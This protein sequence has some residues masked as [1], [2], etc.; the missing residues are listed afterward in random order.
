MSASEVTRHRWLGDQHRRWTCTRRVPPMR[1]D[2][3]VCFGCGFEILYTA[4][5][6]DDVNDLANRPLAAQ[7]LALRL[8]L[9]AETVETAASIDWASPKVGRA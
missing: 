7:N 9:R 4:I 8:D 6:T 3:D 1:S 2:G 5:R